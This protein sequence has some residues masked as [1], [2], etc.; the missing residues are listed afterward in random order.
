MVSNDPSFSPVNRKVRYL[1]LDAYLICFNSFPK[2]LYCIA[3]FHTQALSKLLTKTLFKSILNKRL[4]NLRVGNSFAIAFST[5][6]TIK[7]LFLLQLFHFYN[8][9][10]SNLLYCSVYVKYF[11]ISCPI[12]H[13]PCSVP[14]L[15]VTPWL[16]RSPRGQSLISLTTR[17]HLTLL[18]SLICLLQSSILHSQIIKSS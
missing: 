12:C 1:F 9:F 3:W 4:D 17:L 8:F 15:R 14:S 18:D 5:I 6:S 11:P 13:S 7:P 2:L 16:Y 10:Y